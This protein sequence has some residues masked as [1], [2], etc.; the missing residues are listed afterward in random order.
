LVRTTFAG[1]F[2]A[3]TRQ[4]TVAALEL[5]KHLIMASAR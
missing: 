1:P 2:P 5:A 3:V 4:Q